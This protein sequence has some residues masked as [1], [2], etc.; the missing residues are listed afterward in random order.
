MKRI[1]FDGK[2]FLARFVTNTADLII[3][4]NTGDSHH[5]TLNHERID[6]TTD[7]IANEFPKE[8]ELAKAKEWAR[9]ILS[10]GS[11]KVA[12][13][14]G[15]ISSMNSWTSIVE[16]FKQNIKVEGRLFKGKFHF[17]V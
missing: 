3:N 15:K 5:E 17:F 1:C 6:Q 10:Q 8:T 4:D 12:E 11:K 13:Q 7:Q 16:F 2:I 9:Q 14:F